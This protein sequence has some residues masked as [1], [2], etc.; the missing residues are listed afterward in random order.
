MFILQFEAEYHLWSVHC[1]SLFLL[2]F[3]NSF[4]H[5]LIEQIFLEKQLGARDTGA[6][7]IDLFPVFTI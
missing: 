4:I 1:Y 5:S 7:G 6:N 2:L 3:P